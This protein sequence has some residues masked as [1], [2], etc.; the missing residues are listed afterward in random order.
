[1]VSLCRQISFLAQWNIAV[2][3][4]IFGGKFRRFDISRLLPQG[5]T[6]LIPFRQV[7]KSLCPE[8]D[9]CRDSAA[10]QLLW[11]ANYLH[12]LLG[13]LKMVL[14]RALFQGNLLDSICCLSKYYAVR[15]HRPLI[16]SAASSKI[17]HGI[18]PSTL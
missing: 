9:T 15:T 17:Q 13:L 11:K 2:P 1:M 12:Y 5:R 7:F 14:S 10:F 16:F 18:R 8:L 4:C 3:H 6:L